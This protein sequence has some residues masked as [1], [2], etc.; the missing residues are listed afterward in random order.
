MIDNEAHVFDDEYFVT[1]RI[2]TYARDHCCMYI[3]QSPY[4]YVKPD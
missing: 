1:F 3:V 4:A 2:L